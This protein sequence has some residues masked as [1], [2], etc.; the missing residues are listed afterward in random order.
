SVFG[1]AGEGRGKAQRFRRAQRFPSYRFGWGYACR[2]VVLVGGALAELW[3]GWRSASALRSSSTLNG[4]FSRGGRALIHRQVHD[5]ALRYS[6]PARADRYLNRASGG[7]G[8][9]GESQRDAAISR[10][11]DGCRSK[12]GR[13]AARNIDRCEIQG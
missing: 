10:R 6:A 8:G 4:G 9:F 5:D 12:A 3:F 7:S 2:V 13:H 11:V 1:G